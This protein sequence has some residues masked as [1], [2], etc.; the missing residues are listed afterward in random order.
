M[1]CSMWENGIDESSTGQ[2]KVADFCEHGNEPSYSTK[3]EGYSW[4]AKDW[5]ASQEGL[6]RGV[7]CLCEIWGPV[8]GDYEMY[9]LVECDA[10]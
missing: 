2:E 10:L 3:Y 5:L 8:S 9:C 4:P 6:F 1:P 7:I